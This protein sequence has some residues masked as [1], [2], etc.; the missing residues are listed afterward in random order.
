LIFYQGRKFVKKIDEQIEREPAEIFQIPQGFRS[1]RMMMQ[2]NGLIN[3]FSKITAEPICLTGMELFAI[4]FQ[5]L[6]AV[7][8]EL[9][10]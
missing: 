6:G 3:E 9:V 7:S 2:W 8:S 1:L 5:F 4:N 10:F